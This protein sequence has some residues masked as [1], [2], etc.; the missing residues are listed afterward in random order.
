MIR[1]A[2]RR[3]STARPFRILGLQQ[4]AVGHED[5]QALSDFWL[6]TLG[7]EQKG[8]FRSERENVD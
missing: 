5:K 6:G 8:T 7:L 3:F 2:L 1:A 4:I